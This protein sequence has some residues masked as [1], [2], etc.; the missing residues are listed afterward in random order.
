ML[1]DFAQRALYRLVLS[2]TTELSNRTS[3]QFPSSDLVET[4]KRLR[5]IL[6]PLPGALV[7]L[8]SSLIQ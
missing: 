4:M 1:F 6:L 2:Q 7:S 5:V 8:Q 3:L